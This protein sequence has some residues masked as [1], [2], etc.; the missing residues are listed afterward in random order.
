VRHNYI[1]SFYKI[2]T[3]YILKY[4]DTSSSL[5]AAAFQTS[6]R[7]I[8]WLQRVRHIVYMCSFFYKWA[9]SFSFTATFKRKTLNFSESFQIR[10]AWK[11][12]KNI[13]S[14]MKPNIA[15]RQP[16]MKRA[17]NPTKSFSLKGSFR[18]R[19]TRG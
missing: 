1:Y 9:N 8:K 17:K 7:Q 3:K 16:P 15:I 14:V 4:K 5:S 11:V 13:N 10:I 18:A 12:K 19:P 6:S 2:S